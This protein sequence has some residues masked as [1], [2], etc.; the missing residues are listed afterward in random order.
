MDK[1]LDVAVFSIW[2]TVFAVLMPKACDAQ[3][4]NEQ[5]KTERFLAK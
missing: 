2:I 3:W 5:A 4:D 1:I